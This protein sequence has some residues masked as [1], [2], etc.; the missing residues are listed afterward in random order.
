MKL[1]IYQHC[2][3]CLRVVL[4]RGLKQLD[5][6]VQVV[7][8]NDVDTPT[9]L[10]G[11]KKVPILQKADGS[12]MPESMD[13]VR[14]LDAQFAPPLLTAAERPE[15]DAWSERASGLIFRLAVPRITCGDFAELAT[16]EA[17]A[18]YI[19]REIRAFGD[20]EALL[21]AT[22]EMLAELA[23]LLDELD[24]LIP[25]PDSALG[26]SDIRLF[27]LLALLSIVKDARLPPRVAT[28]Y[29]TLSTRSGLDDFSA[30]AQ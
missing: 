24:D 16:P 6:P 3:F 25:P 9:R 29:S 13:I 30:Q 23:P 27:P 26:E 5:L 19:E 15:I 11:R 18:A 10:I 22:P 17:R 14:Y 21:A 1:Y 12:A 2:P 20:L 4:L 7:L 8:E 28:W